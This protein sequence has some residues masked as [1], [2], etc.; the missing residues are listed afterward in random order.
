LT[1][2][3]TVTNRQTDTTVNNSTLAVW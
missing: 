3:Q 1:D 2:R